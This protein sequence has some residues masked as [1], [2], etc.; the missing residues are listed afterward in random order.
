MLQMLEDGE[1]DAAVLAS[2]P[3]DKTHIKPVFA[4]PAEDGQ[5]WYAQHRVIQINHMVVLKGPTAR[6]HPQLPAD[7]MALIRQ[8]RQF[9]LSMEE[10]D[11]HPMGLDAVRPHLE[12]AIDMVH[13]QGLIRSRPKLEDLFHPATGIE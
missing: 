5:A 3:A 8:S 11:A 9:G 13:R 12:F 2:A 10:F 1:L 7:L 6:G 4:N